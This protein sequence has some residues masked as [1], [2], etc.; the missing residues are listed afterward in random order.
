MLSRAEQIKQTSQEIKINMV[1]KQVKTCQNHRKPAKNV[2]VMG[3]TRRS[4]IYKICSLIMNSGG[5]TAP[6]TIGHELRAVLP[7]VRVV[8]HAQ[9]ALEAALG[10][11]NAI[12]ARPPERLH[13]ISRG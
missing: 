13:L 6:P 8:A 4:I 9:P 12:A 2:I 11:I 1:S 10:H 7:Q 5:L 3:G